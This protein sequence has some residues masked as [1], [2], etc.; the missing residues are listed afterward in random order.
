MVE[1]SFILG[2]LFVVNPVT[3][4]RMLGLNKNIFNSIVILIT[5]EESIQLFKKLLGE[6]LV[7]IT[8]T[9]WLLG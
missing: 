8:L 2:E 7:R 5:K 9:F 4:Y 3:K 6:H 1:I